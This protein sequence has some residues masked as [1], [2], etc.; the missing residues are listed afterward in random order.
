MEGFDRDW[1]VGSIPSAI[2]TGLPAGDYVFM[3][4]AANN[5][6][7]WGEAA[8][9][10]VTIRPPFWRTWWAYCFYVL[11]AA[12]VIF[13]VMRYLLLRERMK[14]EGALHQAKLSFFTNISHEIRTHLALIGG[15]VEKMLLRKRDEEDRRQLNYI[16]KNSESLLQLVRELMDFRKAEAGHMTLR[17]SKGDIVA[18]TGEIVQRWEPM[19]ADRAIRLDFAPSAESISLPFDAEQ[20]EK[21]I[22]NL[23]TNALKFTPDGGDIDVLIEENRSVVE[24]RVLDNGKGIAAENLPK[25]FTNYYQELEYGVRNTGYGIGL[26]LAKTIVEL[27]KGQLNVESEPG[28]LT[29][30]TVILPKKSLSMSTTVPEPL[31]GLLERPELSPMTEDA[32]GEKKYTVLVVEDNPEL[33]SFLRSALDDQYDVIEAADGLKGWDTA[34]EELPD[35]I[36]TDVMMPGMDGYKLCGKLKSD[37]RTSHI[38]TV[39]LTARSSMAD[40][41][42]GLEMG[43]DIYLAKPF[44]I[45]ILRLHLRNLLAAREKLRRRYVQE[46]ATPS[47]GG[48]DP[49]AAAVPTVDDQFM[50]KALDFIEEKM[51]EPEFGVPMLSTHMLMSQPILYKK[52][53]ALTDMS[54]NDF[55]KSVRLKRA[56]RLLLEKSHTVIEV[57]YMVGYTD[58][59]HF[60]KE[61]K[62]MF[63]VTPGEYGKAPK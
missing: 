40:Q 48:A 7:I 19:A 45:H 17:V 3:V 6:G 63:G 58:R 37:S 53:K 33:R 34:I 26:A 21:V 41:I 59:K 5:D 50:K 57:V 4:K 14:Q 44:S 46:I 30:F 56:A 24:I 51:D 55:I 13:L 60:A 52:I 36:I 1:I 29:C 43:A 27:H 47:A 42:S 31:E 18:F 39:L 10:K 35:L 49:S 20:L 16:K 38:P 25:L 23:L 9:L 8:M 15:P 11:V 2:Y 32:P 28:V 61:F 54:V 62:K 22:V 12:A